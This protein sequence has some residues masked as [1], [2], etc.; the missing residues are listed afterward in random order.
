MVR[1][2]GRCVKSVVQAMCGHVMG[3]CTRVFDPGMFC[4][5]HN[6][7]NEVRGIMRVVC[8]VRVVRGEFSGAC[9]EVLQ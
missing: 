4:K 7:D 9:K 6:K 3:S 8:V 1:V 5:Y 2:S